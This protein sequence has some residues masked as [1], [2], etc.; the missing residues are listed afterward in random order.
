MLL[1]A[2]GSGVSYGATPGPAPS[3]SAATG[4]ISD[5]EMVVLYKRLLGQP[6]LLGF[7]PDKKHFDKV[8]E[9]VKTTH[10]DQPRDGELID[11]VIAE[12]RLLARAADASSAPLDSMVHDRNAPERI[13]A[14]YA[15][16]MDPSVLWFSMLTG[17]MKGTHDRW[18]A[19]MTPRQFKSLSGSLNS[20]EMLG[21]GVYVDQDPQ[22]HVTTVEQTIEGSPAD[23]AGLLSGDE[24]VKINGNLTHDMSLETVYKELRGAD[25]TAT[26]YVNYHRPGENGEHLTS[27]QRA[28]FAMPSATS[29]MIG[30]D[31]GYVR[32]YSFGMVTAN[33][34]KEAIEDFTRKGAKGLIIDVR[35][36][37]GGYA[38]AGA[39]VCS[40]FLPPDSVISQMVD[41]T[42][43]HPHLRGG[44][45]SR[46][47][48]PTVLLVNENSASASELTAACLKDYGVATLIG[49]HTYGKGCQQEVFTLDDG[50]AYK[51]TNCYFIGPRGTKINKVGIQPDIK[52]DMERRWVGKGDKDTQLARALRFLRT[53][54]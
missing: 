26:I 50:S 51:I 54:R 3:P 12:V 34:L 15:G 31:I 27:M 29:A 7:K 49:N 6:A 30:N 41:K 40:L 28:V 19:Y 8:F 22:T 36:N 23:Q 37:G 43:T 11:G 18:T 38:H 17:L 24:I 20:A 25:R 42:G 2:G 48:L 1:L 16:K 32:L 10:V 21:I 4:E 39:D 45:I 13:A 14:A 53:G 47:R 35:N 44:S 46:V 33:R 5:S 52:V 9:S